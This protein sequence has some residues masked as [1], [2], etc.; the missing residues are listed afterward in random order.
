MPLT[1]DALSSWE[2]AQ[3]VLGFSSE[4]QAMA[5][6]LI[7]AASAYANR[8]AGRQLRARTVDLHLDGT[9]SASLVLPES[10][11]IVSKLWV[12]TAR[13]FANGQELLPADYQVFGEA[14]IIRLYDGL[15]PDGFGIVRVQGTLGFEPAPADLE[16]AVLECVA[17][18]LRRLRGKGAIGLKSISIDGATSSSYEIDWPTT[19]VMVFDSYRRPRV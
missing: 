1:A 16:Q 17:V 3:A 14:G 8:R 9:G 5:E 10:P 15:F 11:A 13:E 2:Q 4:D 19:A 6:F 7:N 12:D 18:N